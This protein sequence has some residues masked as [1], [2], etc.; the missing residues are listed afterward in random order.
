MTIHLP[1][2][3]LLIKEIPKLGS[4]KI[5]FIVTKKITLV[6]DKE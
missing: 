5:D 2:E 1:A 3:L 4:D 6:N